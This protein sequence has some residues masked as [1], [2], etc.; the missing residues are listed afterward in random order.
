MLCAKASNAGD[1][2]VREATLAGVPALLRIP[3][4]IHKPPIIL[5]H[6]FGPPA[7]ERAMM[8]ALP[9]DDVDAVKVYLGLPLFGA[10]APEGGTKELARRQTE[11][12]GLL[13][14]K[15]VVAGAADEL[16]QVVDALQ[17]NACM[18]HGAPV[19][20]VGFS[21]GGAAALDALSQRKVAIDAAVFINASTGLSAS[22]QAYEKATGK[23]YAWSP[24]S[25]ELAKETDAIDHASD[26]A[27]HHPALLFLQGADDAV[28]DSQAASQLFDRLKP[29]YG[30]QPQRL[31]FTRP[32]GMTHQWT[33][34]PPTLESVRKATA[35]WFVGHLP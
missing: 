29:L 25:R 24:A 35:D 28:I 17:A 34:D 21:A 2:L 6:G 15:P 32:A 5:W 14:F 13:V 20:L 10:R 4:H 31:Q 23:T 7:S 27:A 1:P 19:A 12:V 9:L 22:I 16:P 30:E 11:D 26:I 8:D 3:A 33:A 18:Q